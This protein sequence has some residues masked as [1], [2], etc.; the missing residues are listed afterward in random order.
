VF[1][2]QQAL[3]E[4]LDQG[5]IVLS[6]SELSIG[7]HSVRF[8]LEGALLFVADVSETGDPHRLVGK[9]KSLEDVQALD[10]EHCADSVVLGESAYQVTEGFMGQLLAPADAASSSP[11]GMTGLDAGHP[12]A[13]LIERLQTR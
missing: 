1:F 13:Q 2:P 3:D 7:G 10:G 11:K 6:G 12:L 5:R 9:V 8:R 4:W